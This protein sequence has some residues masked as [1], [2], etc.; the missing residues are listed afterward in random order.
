MA[1]RERAATTVIVPTWNRA[2]LLARCLDAVRATA[3]CDVLVV[4]NGS[5]DETPAVIAEAGVGSIVNP[6]NR[7][8][9][10]ACNQGAE[11][12]QTENVCFLN[13]DTEPKPGWLEAMERHARHAIVGCQLIERKTGQTHHAG[14]GFEPIGIS[15]SENGH[16]RQRFEFRA[17]E[18]GGVRPSGP[19]AAVT[20]ACLLVRRET[21]LRLGGFD[22]AFRNGYED[23]DLCLRAQSSGVPVWYE[24][25]AVVIHD[26]FGS[27]MAERKPYMKRNARLLFERWGIR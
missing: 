9:A 20:G 24:P 11:A 2:H 26:R 1:T 5:T 22:P 23:V 19:A 4:D 14:I 18:L 25:K 7:G 17:R 15:T 10:V 13:N 6:D 21:F 8:F 12:A 27:G 16:L 3:E